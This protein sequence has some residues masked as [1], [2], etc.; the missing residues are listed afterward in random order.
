MFGHGDS[1]NAAIDSVAENWAN[2]PQSAICQLFH[3]PRKPRLSFISYPSD[4][5]DRALPWRG[6]ASGV[7]GFVASAPAESALEL[8]PE[9]FFLDALGSS[10]ADRLAAR[11]LISLLAVYT[12]CGTEADS[13]VYFDGFVDADASAALAATTPPPIHQNTPIVCQKIYI[14]LEPCE[15][16]EVDRDKFPTPRGE[17]APASPRSR[18]WWQRL[19]GR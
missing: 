15:W 1:R 10:I 11:E 18:S 6:T 5:P 14:L 2:G 13:T 9:A 3:N 12:L 7:Y 16:D 8:Y 4:E 17:A 19:I